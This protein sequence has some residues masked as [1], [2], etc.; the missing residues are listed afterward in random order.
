M[1]PIFL[2]IAWKSVRIIPISCICNDPILTP[3]SVCRNTRLAKLDD[4]NSQ[5]TALILARAGLVRLDMGDR[6]TA[7]IT[8]PTLLHAVG[9]GALAVEIRSNDDGAKQILKGI[10]HRV[11]AWRCSAERACLRVLEGGCSVPV[12]VESSIVEERIDV[13][14]EVVSRSTLTLTGTVTSL[15]G[16]K[17]VVQTL[18][19]AVGSLKEAE[20]V[21]EAVAR[22]LIE[23]G[24]KDILAEIGKD[25]EA[26]LAKESK[27]DKPHEGTTATN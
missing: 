14:G 10:E 15:S 2:S 16:T 24:A 17:H 5:Y 9:Q 25:R 4:P 18:T 27:A 23:N 7:N 13:D 6:V 8:S 11:S 22:T 3:P 21:G 1:P 12:G 19:K 20:V 26:R